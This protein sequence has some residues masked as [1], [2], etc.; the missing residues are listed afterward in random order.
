[1]KPFK[2]SPDIKSAPLPIIGQD[3]QLFGESKRLGGIYLPQDLMT[4]LSDVNLKAKKKITFLSSVVSLCISLSI[5]I[6]GGGGISDA[7]D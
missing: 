6:E 4:F 3:I 7:P 5:V 2:E 1:M